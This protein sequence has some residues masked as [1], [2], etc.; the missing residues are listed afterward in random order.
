[1]GRLWN[2]Y[3]QHGTRA[4]LQ[5]LRAAVQRASSSIGRMELYVC[6]LP[7]TPIAEPSSLGVLERIS[8]LSSLKA[9]DLARLVSHWNPKVKRRQINERFATHAELWL[10]RC[11]GFIAAYGWTIKGQTIEPHFSPL[12]PRDVHL[13]DFF[14]FPEFRGRGLNPALVSRILLAVG[15]EGLTRA[16]IEAAAWNQAQL[17]SLRKTPFRPLGAARRLCLGKSVLVL[18]SN[19][20][21]RQ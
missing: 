10:L 17:A 15:Q 19:K 18:W 7:T 14:V 9:E 6:D 21:T 2:Y 8:G 3:R 5:R 12:T 20:N 13:F 16:F 1:M 4:T 11:N